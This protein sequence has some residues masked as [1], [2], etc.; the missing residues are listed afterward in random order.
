MAGKP[1]YDLQHLQ[2]LIG[3]GAISRV[4]TD[5]A[6]NGGF[7][8]SLGQEDI[9]EAVLA[10]HAGDFYKTMESERIPGLWQDVYHLEY[11]GVSLY[12]KLQIGFDGRAYVV[13]FKRR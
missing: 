13:Q 4:I 2:H 9:V 8:L 10:L 7:A 12:I 11:R 5:A 3:Q 1:T 6:S